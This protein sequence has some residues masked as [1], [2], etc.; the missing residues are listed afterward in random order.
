MGNHRAQRKNLPVPNRHTEGHR[1]HYVLV[2]LQICT[3]H[4]ISKCMRRTHPVDRMSS[5]LES[6]QY[7][8]QVSELQCPNW[9]LPRDLPPLLNLLNIA[10]Q[11]GSENLLYNSL[12][13]VPS[14]DSYKPGRKFNTDR[15]E[16]PVPLKTHQVLTP[17]LT[18][19]IHLLPFT[20]Q[21]LNTTCS[22][23]LTSISVSIHQNAVLNKHT[24][25]G[26]CLSSGFYCSDKHNA[27]RNLGQKGFI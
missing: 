6:E 2:N 20:A 9:R 10:D 27:Q 11:A 18:P 1:L 8:L 23:G 24:A 7:N 17:F 14:E 16:S 21:Y 3:H 13:P 12:D 4:N 19:F 5:T 15:T 25:F 26:N 22:C